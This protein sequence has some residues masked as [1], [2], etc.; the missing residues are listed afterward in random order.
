MK[1]TFGGV[2][3][4]LVV[5]GCVADAGSRYVRDDARVS[6]AQGE[7]TVRP[8]ASLLPV[9]PEERF[10]QLVPR[11]KVFMGGQGDHDGGVEHC[12]YPP[13]ADR[14]GVLVLTRE[15][16]MNRPERWFWLY[17]EESWMRGDAYLHELMSTQHL[18]P[19]DL[20]GILQALHDAGEAPPPVP[21]SGIVT[22]RAFEGAPNGAPPLGDPGGDHRGSS[23]SS[24]RAKAPDPGG[25]APRTSGGF[26][27]NNRWT[28]PTYHPKPKSDAQ[29]QEDRLEREERRNGVRRDEEPRY[30]TPD[31]T[32]VPAPGEKEEAFKCEGLVYYGYKGG[33]IDFQEKPTSVKWEMKIGEF[34]RRNTAPFHDFIYHHI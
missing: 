12:G 1:K 34:M 5:S 24:G 8:P 22:G 6:E 7:L 27:P 11:W 28:W 16:D 4:A 29:C 21:G 17:L 9:T 20:I 18:T 30:G 13:N 32:Y 14:A 26:D 33:C 31:D 25:S 3:L 23:S 10:Y 19:L 2:A 15:K